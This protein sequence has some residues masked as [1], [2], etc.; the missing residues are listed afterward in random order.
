MLKYLEDNGVEMI[1]SMS[2]TNI[3]AQFEEIVKQKSAKPRDELDSPVNESIPGP[4][5]SGQSPHTESNASHHHEQ[6][7]TPVKSGYSGDIDK[8]L[9]LVQA[10]IALAELQLKVFSSQGNA[11]NVIEKKSSCRHLQT[12][13]FLVSV[14]EYSGEK[15][16][17]QKWILSATVTSYGGDHDDKY[18]VA[19]GLITGL[20]RAHVNKKYMT[21]WISLRSTLLERFK[22]D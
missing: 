19:R 21:D 6:Q 3:R 20:A 15:G 17:A 5:N 14:G 12:K 16:S 10:K 1:R 2:I 4:S 13:E 8:E 9:E 11:Q 22:D 18:R 7:A